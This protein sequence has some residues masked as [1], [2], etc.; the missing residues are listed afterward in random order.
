MPSFAFGIPIRV[1][2]NFGNI[3]WY[4][5]KSVWKDLLD[6][7]ENLGYLVIDIRRIATPLSPD[8]LR[9]A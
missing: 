3:R 1:G 5:L 6:V 2:Y 8:F 9:V 7:L 4:R